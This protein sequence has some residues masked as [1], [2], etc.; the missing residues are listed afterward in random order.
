MCLKTFLGGDAQ[1]IEIII[2]HHNQRPEGLFLE[3]K[4]G[5]QGTWKQFPPLRQIRTW[6]EHENRGGQHKAYLEISDWI[7][8]TLDRV[9]TLA[10]VYEVI[11]SK[12]L[13]SGLF[14]GLR[15]RNC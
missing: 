9:E 12:I 7:G 5:K 10:Y 2:Q 14:F 13:E 8:Y 3:K 1:L 4:R 11:R 6:E 15:I